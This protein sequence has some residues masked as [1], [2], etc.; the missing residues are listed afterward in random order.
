M[1]RHWGQPLAAWVVLLLYPLTPLLLLTL[2][3]ESAFYNA[4]I[5]AGL[6]ACMQ[7]QLRWMALWL[8]LA[9]LTR[10]DA[11]VAVIACG[12]Y[13][14]GV[15]SQESG[16]RRLRPLI[17]QSLLPLREKG[18]T[19]DCPLPEA[20]LPFRERGWGEGQN[21]ILIYAVLVLPWFVFAWWYFG[22][23]F[24]VTLAAKQ[25]QGALPESRSFLAGLALEVQ[26]YALLPQYWAALVL[27]ALGALGALRTSAR[28]WLLFGWALAYI[29]AYTALGVSAYFW[30]YAPLVGPLVSAVGL[31]TQ[32]VARLPRE[33]SL[34]H[35]G[36]GGWGVR[37]WARHATPL[38][39]VV[40]LAAQVHAVLTL[41]RDGRL[42]LYRETGLWLRANTAP[43]ATV[44]ALEVGII[45]YYSQ[46]PM[47]DFAGLIQ[48]A[49]AAQIAD[50]ASYDA[51]ARWATLHYTPDYIVLAGG[52]LPS[53]HSD[54]Q[55]SAACARRRG[56]PPS[57]ARNQCLSSLVIGQSEH[58]EPQYLVC[59]DAG[60]ARRF[61]CARPRTRPGCG[62]HLLPRCCRCYRLPG[63]TLR[64]LLA[65]QRRS[66]RLRLPDR[67]A[68]R[69]DDHRQYYTASPAM[70][71]A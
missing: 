10:A 55:I 12:V 39:V 7:R 29:A 1:A 33:R 52:S 31:G 32:H 70:D 58:Y 36:R 5:Y 27:A 51:A 41:P 17:P 34:F 25:A 50:G 67:P 60:V 16:V 71:G 37:D 28:R 9:T 4:L 45:G 54:T 43:E 62:A 68:R 30:Y 59:T 19:P 66:A 40:M 48:P 22:T 35:L 56:S 42:A 53:L 47:I 14:L 23:A 49:V 57:T 44:A 63:R 46:R 11:L 26:R 69:G 3:A 2:G 61:S 21:A 65:A 15:R 24:P 64:R 38:L 13:F 18:S 8:G 20:P 6:L